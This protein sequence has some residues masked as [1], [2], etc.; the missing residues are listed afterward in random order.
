[1]VP[2][3]PFSNLVIVWLVSPF[4]ARLQGIPRRIHLLLFLLLFLN[5]DRDLLAVGQ[6]RE[7]ARAS[8]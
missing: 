2:R 4:L 5:L 8:P 1:M 3:S 7:N 6:A